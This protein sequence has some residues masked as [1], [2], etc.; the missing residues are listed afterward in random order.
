[1]PRPGVGI[2][3]LWKTSARFPHRTAK[4]AK[5]AEIFV[6][7]AL[8]EGQLP[9]AFGRLSAFADIPKASMQ[10]DAQRKSAPGRPISNQRKGEG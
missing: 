3:S 5:G 8:T 2:G 9:W 7:F 6:F 10:I 4:N 1:M